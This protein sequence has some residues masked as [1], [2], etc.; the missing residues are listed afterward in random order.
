MSNVFVE[1]KYVDLLIIFSLIIIFF[2]L[3]TF[4]NFILNRQY[5]TIFQMSY[6]NEY[7][8]FFTTYSSR[9]I[10]I[11]IIS[12]SIFYFYPYKN[13]GNITILCIGLASFIQIWPTVIN[14]KLLKA[15]QTYLKRK[16]LLS[17]VLY[18]LL[19]I[20]IVFIAYQFLF[21]SPNQPSFLI[22]DNLF[23]RILLSLLSFS[24]IPLI[25]LRL[26]TSTIERR[27]INI[28]TFQTEIEALKET[29]LTERES[30]DYFRY[31]II[32]AAQKYQINPNLLYG[33]LLLEHINRGSYYIR[34]LEN[35]L[36]RF[37]SRLAIKLDISVGIG[38]IKLSSAEKGL[39]ISRV[40]LV[41]DILEPKFNINACASYIKFLEDC[42]N[43]NYSKI[44]NDQ[45]NCFEYNP[46][47][48]ILYQYTNRLTDDYTFKL[49]FELLKIIISENWCGEENEE[50]EVYMYIN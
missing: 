43:F 7:K 44:E 19:N 1:I 50:Y 15:R 24:T 14:Y 2:L 31:E 34:I 26:F 41:K 6:Y 29:V 36:C 49:Y 22:I 48:T 35:F 45:Y 40:L 10:V 39:K 17:C 37:L 38:Q 16:Y 47:R 27:E 9:V 21:I 42:Y 33:I 13:K 25:F 32:A 3:N 18:V 46:D 20:L 5:S 28:D 4:L 12:F 8:S 11:L 23:V 30:I